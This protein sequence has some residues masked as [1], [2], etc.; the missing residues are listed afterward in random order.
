MPRVKTYLD[1]KERGLTPESIIF[2]EDAATNEIAKNQLKDLFDGKAFF[3][4]PKPV[5]LIKILLKISSQ[6]GVILDFS[7]GWAPRPKP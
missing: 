5:D 1:A 2:A 3:D 4:T 6:E 7:L